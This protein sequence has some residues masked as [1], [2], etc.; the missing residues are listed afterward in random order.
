MKLEPYICPQCGG[1]VNSARMVC[2]YCGAQFKQQQEVVKIIAERPGIHTLS[3]GVAISDEALNVLG[4]E[5][6]SEMA[7]HE[8]AKKM[9]KCIMP[10]ISIQTSDNE[11]WLENT[12][13]VRGRLRVVDPKEWSR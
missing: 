4:P 1:K 11:L 2:E 9:S 7:L 3:A 6:A 5:K 10:F 12:R 8:I 13:T